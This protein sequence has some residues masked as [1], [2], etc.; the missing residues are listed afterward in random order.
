VNIACA[1]N[2]ADIIPEIQKT[3]C[4]EDQTNEKVN[5]LKKLLITIGKILKGISFH[6]WIVLLLEVVWT[7]CCYYCDV[8]TENSAALRGRLVSAGASPQLPTLRRIQ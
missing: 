7:R 3:E 6:F 5:L 1:H 8:R 4:K 2:I